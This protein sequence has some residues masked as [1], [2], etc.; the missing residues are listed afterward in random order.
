MGL[1]DKYLTYGNIDDNP[2]DQSYSLGL[3]D[4]VDLPDFN[5]ETYATYQDTPSRADSYKSKL[6]EMMGKWDED[7]R[8]GVDEQDK[9][10]AKDQ[11]WSELGKRLAKA[12]FS[13]SYQGYGNA[14]QDL[15]SAMG[16]A[17]SK[18]LDTASNKNLM[19]EL[20][21]LDMEKNISQAEKDR[22]ALE[23]AQND[24]DDKQ[25]ARVMGAQ[26]Y[27]AEMPPEKVELLVS[28][29]KDPGQ[30][31]IVASKLNIARLYMHA[32]DTDRAMKEMEDA[33]NMVPATAQERID[34]LYKAKEAEAEA[35]AKGGAEG[36]FNAQLDAAEKLPKGFV[37]GPGGNIETRDPLED[38]IRQQQ[39]A[40]SKA[41]VADMAEDNARKKREE[42]KQTATELRY[43]QGLKKDLFKALSDMASLKAR[44]YQFKDGKLWSIAEKRFMDM[45][46]DAFGE[47][48]KT[49]EQLLALGGNAIG[50]LSRYPQLGDYMK[51]YGNPTT[52]IN[53]MMEDEKQ[54][55][56]MPVSPGGGRRSVDTRPKN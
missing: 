38:Q 4:E 46:E 1:F 45:P 47:K 9:A 30:R 10:F 22:L 28:S 15:G 43:E 13:H 6:S 53:A 27:D 12:G 24:F 50:Q 42:E 7:G 49:L 2:D 26:I 17:E 33:M 5:A 36:K 37:M 44:G 11:K 19:V 25:K 3:N 8:Y 56:F 52:A 55:R 18:A 14:M 48:G 31:A 16:G 35:T 20:A 23:I 39:L 40:E 32:G 21:K 34:M 29:V 51:R 54:N 41:R